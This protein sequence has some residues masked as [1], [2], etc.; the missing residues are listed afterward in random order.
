MVPRKLTES[1]AR[2][3]ASWKAAGRRARSSAMAEAVGRICEASIEAQRKRVTVSIIGK[4]ETSR[5][6]RPVTVDQRAGLATIGHAVSRVH[7]SGGGRAALHR[8]PF[9]HRRIGE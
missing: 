8:D 6:K 5:Q 4:W 2:P 1:P 7:V 9:E 3:N